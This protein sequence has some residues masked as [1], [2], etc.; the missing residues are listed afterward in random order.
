MP[1]IL[2]I[3]PGYALIGYAVLETGSGSG[4]QKLVV[5]DVIETSK[6]TGFTDRVLKVKKELVSIIE[7]Y[8]PDEVAI[9]ELFFSR[10]VTT[11]IKVAEMRGVIILTLAEQGFAINE[12]KPAEVKQAFTG[13]GN[14]GKQQIQKMAKMIFGIS[15]KPDDAADAVAIAF[16]HLSKGA[17]RERVRG[18]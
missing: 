4:F 15:I 8:R 11:G 17:F 3:D 13:S 12:Y 10:N 2:G 6:K 5:A 7:E 14:A 9:E 18:S 1:R 16:C